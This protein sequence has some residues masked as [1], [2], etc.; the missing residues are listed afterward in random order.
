MASNY[1]QISPLCR[2]AD[3]TVSNSHDSIINRKLLILYHGKNE[4]IQQINHSRFPA[5]A[6]TS[7]FPKVIAGDTE[8]STFLSEINKTNKCVS[9]SLQL[10]INLTR[11][12]GLQRASYIKNLRLFIFFLSFGK[13][14][15]AHRAGQI[16]G[17]SA[18]VGAPSR[19]WAPPLRCSGWN[20]R[21]VLIRFGVRFVLSASAAQPQ[22]LILKR[23]KISSFG[24]EQ[25]YY[26]Q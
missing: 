14:L 18:G 22:V 10:T 11:R 4:P 15:L 13:S 16:I 17:I 21:R 25:S 2:R 23:Q 8:Y 3:I 5:T 19:D 6:G 9:L 20:F 7:I 24:S 26:K 1:K 12:A